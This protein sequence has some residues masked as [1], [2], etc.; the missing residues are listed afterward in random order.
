MWLPRLSINEAICS[1]IRTSMKTPF[2]ISQAAKTKKPSAFRDG[3]KYNM[4]EHSFYF[5]MP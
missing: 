5:A 2:R 1:C 4:T 3:R